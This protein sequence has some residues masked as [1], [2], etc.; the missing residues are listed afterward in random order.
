M[1][2][3]IVTIGA[4]LCEIMRKELNKPLD[5]AADFTGPYPSGDTPIFINAAAK[6]GAYT[7]MIGAIGNDGFGR[8][9]KNRL[10]EDGCDCSMMKTVDGESTGCTFVCYFKDGSR[11][12]LYHVHHAACGQLNPDD[13][14]IEKLSGTKWMHVTGF[15]MSINQNAANAVYKAIR[16]LPKTVRISF[17]PNIRPE[18]LS[19]EEIKKLCGPVIERA[20][21]IFPSKTE[22]MMFN[23]TD[24]DEEG[25]KIWAS[26]GK[27]VVLK[28][29]E[30]GSRIFYKDDVLDVPTFSVE[31][32]DPTGAGDTFCGAFLT[33]LIKG[34]TL[35]DAAI[36]ANAAGAMSVRKKGPMEGA[37]SLKELEDFIREHKDVVEKQN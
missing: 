16:E 18:S 32:V 19:V 21:V 25:C 31:E 10:V 4:P 7:A 26:Q 23:D 11:N 2:Y 15:T 30:A 12:F 5:R 35:K 17:D 34:M 9:I 8:C 20:S 22:A 3:D 28:N 6:L 29:G 37:P 1:G 24:T 13:I 36:F 14:D 27:L 33:A